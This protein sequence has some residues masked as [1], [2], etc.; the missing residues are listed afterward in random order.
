MHDSEY[1]V[2]SNVS[3]VHAQTS[4]ELHGEKKPWPYVYTIVSKYSIF[5]R[6][7]NYKT[8]GWKRDDDCVY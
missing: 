1:M 4:S 2:L 3:A 6:T 5:F 7:I 8:T